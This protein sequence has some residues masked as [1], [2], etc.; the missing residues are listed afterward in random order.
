MTTH[1]GRTGLH[2]VTLCVSACP[3]VTVGPPSAEPEPERGDAMTSTLMALLCLGTLP[4]PTIWA[5]PGSVIPRGTP[6]TIWCQGSL[7]AWEYHLL[8]EGHSG[9]WDTQMLLES[10]DKAKFTTYM[11]VVYAGRYRCDYLSPTGWSEPSEPLVVTGSHGKPQLSALPSPVVASGGNVTLQCASRLG[12][13]RFV[14]TKEGERQPSSTLDSQQAPSG[15]FQALFPVGPVTPSLRG[16]FRCY[17]Y[18]NNTPQIWSYPSDPLELLVSGAAVRGLFSQC[19]RDASGREGQRSPAAG[20]LAGSEVN[21]HSRCSVKWHRWL[22]PGVARAQ[23]PHWYLYVL[24][25]AAVAF[26]LLLGLFI[27]LLV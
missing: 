24:I 8:N 14:L 3:A 9:S 2:V 25:G 16:T 19:L 10:R 22:S 11:T 21:A 1:T 26:V 5:E 15:Q 12:F 18:Y 4:K 17:G 13:N 20:L 23:G 6:V 27:L 7:E